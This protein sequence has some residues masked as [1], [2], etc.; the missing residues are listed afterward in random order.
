MSTSSV[1][2]TSLGWQLSQWQQRISEQWE[3]IW[4]KLIKNL[5]DIPLP[6]WLNSPLVAVIAKI[7]F[8]LLVAWLSIWIVWKIQRL[9]KLYLRSRKSRINRAIPRTAKTPIRE[10]SVAHWLAQAQQLQQQGNYR[11]A[12]QCLYQA[13]LQQLHD[14]GIVLHQSSR[15]DGEYWQI[16][17]N[18]TQS[19]PYQQL[20]RIHQELCFG[21]IPA[22]LTLF[23]T[24]WQA[25]REIE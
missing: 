18:L 14:K 15:T 21:N 6:S 19:Q 1:E 17:E 25:Y 24:C 13:M 3:L 16:I 7:V 22:S 23:E 8:W 10:G 5:L 9:F 11:G 4:I 20:L 2:T 12:C